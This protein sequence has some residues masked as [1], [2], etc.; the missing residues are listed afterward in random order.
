MRKM[1]IFSA[2]A[3]AA[4]IVAPASGQNLVTNGDFS[5]GLTGWTEWKAAW[6]NAPD[7]DASS[8]ALMLDVNGNGSAGYYQAVDVG[9]GVDVSLDALWGGNVGSGGWAEIMAF[10]MPTNDH[11]A[12]ASRI[13][14][15][16]VAPTDI[17]RK[18]DSWDLGGAGHTW[19]PILASVEGPPFDLSSLNW[20]TSAQYVVI[21]LKAGNTATFTID[22]I[23][24]TPEPTT[25]TMLG[26]ASLPILLRRRKR[27]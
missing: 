1:R 8:G 12:I 25:L 6:G 9:V 10:D 16:S 19:G 13:D 26:L 18:H 2:L 20:T 7:G 11:S 3:V 5:A 14:D 15:G 22:N 23:T 27:A 21:G 17:R 4:L 24:L